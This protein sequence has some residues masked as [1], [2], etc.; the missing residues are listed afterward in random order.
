MEAVSSRFSIASVIDR[1]TY[2]VAKKKP[3]NRIMH[4]RLDGEVK[5]HVGYCRWKWRR[6]VTT[7]A[8]RLIAF[9][10]VL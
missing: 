10:A 4:E 7:C 1:F 5:R 3:E 6:Q 9:L 8:K 2:W